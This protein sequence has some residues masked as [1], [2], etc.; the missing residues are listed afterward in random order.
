MLPKDYITGSLRDAQRR[1]NRS[2]IIFDNEPFYVTNINGGNSSE[3]GGSGKKRTISGYTKGFTAPHNNI[4]MEDHRFSIVGLGSRLGFFNV[5]EETV[6]FAGRVPISGGMVQGLYSGN[7]RMGMYKDGGFIRDISH[8]YDQVIKLDEH[9][10]AHILN[11]ARNYELNTN[12]VTGLCSKGFND[13]FT[14]RFPKAEEVLENSK[15]HVTAVDSRILIERDKFGT[16]YLTYDGQRVG[17]MSKDR[18]SYLES[19]A[20]LRQEVERKTNL[21]AI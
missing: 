15:S 21:K 6:M 17:K 1:F 16:V 14:G 8:N 19:K 7:M 2:I 5:D 4:P 12:F 20:Y 10:K 11:I 13:S 18:V 3:L 9:I